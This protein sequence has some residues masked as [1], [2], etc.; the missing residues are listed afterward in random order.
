MEGCTGMEINDAGAKIITA[1]NTGSSRSRRSKILSFVRS[2]IGPMLF[3]FLA[4][5]F[6]KSANT[7]FRIFRIC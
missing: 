3:L 2:L 7:V 4:F 6:T 5:D 1:Y